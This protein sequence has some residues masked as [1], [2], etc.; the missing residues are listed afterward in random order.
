MR[1]RIVTLAFSPTTG[2]FDDGPL[3]TAVGDHPVLALREHLIHVAGMSYLVCVVA[4]CVG[5]TW[6]TSFRTG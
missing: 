4:R 3:R 2:S 5:R 1:V 6:T